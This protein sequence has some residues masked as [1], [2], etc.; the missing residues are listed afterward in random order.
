[1]STVTDVSLSI[2]KGFAAYPARQGTSDSF[3]LHHILFCE[4]RYQ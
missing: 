4:Q 1:M 2:L 3:N